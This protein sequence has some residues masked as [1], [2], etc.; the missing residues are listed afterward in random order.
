LFLVGVMI[1][2]LLP[3]AD[4]VRFAAFADHSNSTVA[5]INIGRLHDLRHTAA[6]R[7]LKG[8]KA[9]LKVV[10]RLMR[11]EDIATTAK[12]AHA[13]DEDVLE[14]MEA[15]TKSRREVP[16]IVPQVIEKKA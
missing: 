5:P 2:P 8:G 10:Q 16:Q 1:K 3:P 13:Y 11:H 6:T 14:A 12:Y 4:C 7:H 15:E 9:N